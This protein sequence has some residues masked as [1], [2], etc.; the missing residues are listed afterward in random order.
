[1]AI[2]VT[3]STV[4]KKED[5]ADIISNITPTK[6]PFTSMTG[7]ETVHNWAFQW[8][9][10]TLRSSAANAQLEGAAY[11]S[12]DRTEPTLKNNVTQIFNDVFGVSGTTEA[13]SHYGRGSLMAY[14]AANAGK[15]LRLD[16]E[17]A[18]V[19]SGQTMVSP[20][21][22]ASA[23]VM[24]GVQAQIA[25]GNK[26]VTGGAGI[27][28][29][30]ANLLTALNTSYKAGAEPT[31][32]MV[33]PDDSLIV[34]DFAK[35]SGRSRAINSGSGD[36]KKIVNAVELYVSPYGEQKVVINRELRA[37]DMLILDPSMWVKIV[38]KGRDWF[39][40]VLAKVG[41]KVEKAMVGEFSLKNKNSKGSAYIIRST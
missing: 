14:Y 40:E 23:R 38:L 13:V 28:P 31:V 34:A 29:T 20:A 17:R 6:V 18:Y 12:V 24:A 33:T 8:E 22:N 26:V 25:A 5:V 19:G 11:S 9:E 7:K 10:D 36:Q 3:Y 2:Q 39:T 41:D 30:E 32:I 4:G 1:M 35:A 16:V 15:A 21:N 37:S 27:A